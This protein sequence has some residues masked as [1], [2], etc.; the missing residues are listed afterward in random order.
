M[1]NKARQLAGEAAH[2]ISAYL[3][4]PGGNYEPAMQQTRPTVKV[5]PAT[6]LQDHRQKIIRSTPIMATLTERP[7]HSRMAQP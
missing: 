5:T 7:R 3:P 4:E 2:T 1:L 6:P